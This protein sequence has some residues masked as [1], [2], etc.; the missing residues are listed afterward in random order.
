MYLYVKGIKYAS[1]YDFVIGFSNSTDRVIYFVA[2]TASSP[3]EIVCIL[4]GSP[5]FA[6]FFFTCISRFRA[7][8]LHVFKVLVPYCDVPYDFLVTTVF[9][10]YLFSFVL[11]GVHVL[12]MLFVFIYWCPTRFSCHDVRVA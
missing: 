12:L 8:Q 4:S 1:V 11:S 10:S 5:E 6:S 9:G 2:H 3:Y 7:V